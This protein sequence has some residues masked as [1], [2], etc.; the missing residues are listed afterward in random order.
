MKEVKFMACR[1]TI[2]TNN[3]MR[4]ETPTQVSRTEDSISLS[5]GPFYFGVDSATRADTVLQNNLTL[6]DWVT[7]NK[8]YPNYWGRY[9]G[10]EKN[11][12]HEEFKRDA[13]SLLFTTAALKTR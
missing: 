10:G 11:I 4:M 12:T 3:Q 2:G 5:T 7:R 6:F 8:M 9:I 13:K 1:D